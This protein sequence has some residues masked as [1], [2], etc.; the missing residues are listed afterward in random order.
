ML[1]ISLGIGHKKTAN[2]LMMFEVLEL[3]AMPNKKAHGIAASV[4]AFLSIA[5]EIFQVSNIAKK[6]ENALLY[7][8]FIID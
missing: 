8:F 2:F 5:F 4:S 3:P 7:V 1:L 6:S